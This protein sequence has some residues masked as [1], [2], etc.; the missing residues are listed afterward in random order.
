MIELYKQLQ[1]SAIS[2]FTL[3]TAQCYHMEQGHGIEMLRF[4]VNKF[5]PLDN[6]SN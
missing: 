3:M 1:G 6:R 2:F 4:L 5:H